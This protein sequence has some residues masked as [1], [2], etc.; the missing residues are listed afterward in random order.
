MHIIDAL[1]LEGELA[2]E[3]ALLLDLIHRFR[4]AIGGEM[5]LAD[6]TKKKL[7]ALVEALHPPPEPTNTHTKGALLTVRITIA[8][9]DEIAAAAKRVNR[10]VSN[11]VRLTL[12]EHARRR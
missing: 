8:E 10:T 2:A 4:N 12:L 9:R 1:D 6:G 5:R 7:I 3:P 11:W